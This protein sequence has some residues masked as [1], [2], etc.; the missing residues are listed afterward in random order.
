M[1]YLESLA[2]EWFEYQGYFVFRDLWVGWAADGS[3]EAELNVVAY[4]PRKNQLIHLEPSEDLLNWR[5]REQHY[6]LKFDAGKKYLHRM[7]AATP[8][9]HLEQLA[10]VAFPG[11]TARHAVSGAR[12]LFLSELVETILTKLRAF[13][14]MSYLIPERWP[15]LRTL[16]LVAEYRDSV[17]ETLHRSTTPADAREKQTQE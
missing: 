17:C 13:N 3:Y 1:D 7:F 5:E 9:P 2:A 8:S 10:L 14:M 12:I 6:T 4:H 16:Q 15:R 11:A